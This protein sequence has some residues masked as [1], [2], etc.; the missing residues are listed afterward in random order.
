L[1][2]AGESE[3]GSAD[4]NFVGDMR[5]KDG[6][7]YLGGSVSSAGD[8]NGDGH[9]DIL[10]AAEDWEGE[11][12]ASDVGAVYLFDGARL[13]SEGISTFNLRS[14]VHA[15]LHGQFEDERAGVSVA[16][17]GDVNGDGLDD[18]VI[19]TRRGEGSTNPGRAYVVFGR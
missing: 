9:S 2:W 12:T 4:V 8:M 5:V 3:V 1:P 18:V 19:G 16:A 13:S 15:R 11:E 10:L 7:H 17:A 14:D 6:D